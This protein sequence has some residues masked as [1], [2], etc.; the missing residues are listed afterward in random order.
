[1]RQLEAPKREIKRCVD[2]AMA[3]KAAKYSQ[4]DLKHKKEP[5]MPFF[6]FY[7]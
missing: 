2:L 5:L 4:S 1:M 3:P 7:C 6:M